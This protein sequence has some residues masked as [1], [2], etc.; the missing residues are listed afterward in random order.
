[1]AKKKSK[2]AQIGGIGVIYARFS[3]HN[4]RDVSIE[5]QVEA[6]TKKAAE[7]GINIL[8]VY[9]DRA[10]SGKTDKRADFQKMMRDAE[11]GKFQFVVAWK[12]NR[13]GRNMLEAMMNEAKLQA[14]GVRVIYV[15]ENFDDTAA[16]RFAARSMMNVNQFYSESMA[17]DIKRGMVD[18]AKK[19]M[20]NGRPNYGLKKS[21]DGKLEID[22]PAANVLLEIAER[23]IAQEPFVDIYNDLNARG[24]KSPSGGKWNRSSFQNLLTNER[25]RG[26]YIWGDIRIEGGLP[27]LM[28]DEMYYKLQEVLKTKKN[29]RGR[30]RVY[31]DYLLTGKLFCGHCNAPMTGYSGTSKSGALHH[32]YVCQKRRTEHTCKKENV[33]RDD[34]ELAVAQAIRD[35]ALQPDV[36]EW[37]ADSTVAYAKKQ[38]EGSHIAVLEDRLN[39]TNKSI[40]N[41]MNA[42]EQGIFTDTTRERLL[43]LEEEKSNLTIKIKLEKDNIIKVS[44]EDIITGLSMFR[45]GDLNDKNYIAKL[46]DTFLVAVYL[47]DNDMKIVFSFTGKNNTVNLPFDISKLEKAENNTAERCSYKLSSGRPN[48]AQTNTPTIFM[49]D[50]VFVLLCP[51]CKSQ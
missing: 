31:G 3:S 30:H 24:I 48:I 4:Q 22:V 23:V 33:R 41:I 19:C 44:K 29:A 10:V 20:I 11:K 40:N 13:I 32:Y 26:V 46:F 49:V 47:Y 12:S 17:E 2:K 51:F 16:G 15:E 6:A 25:N 35:Y 45:D 42:I 14:W 18:N 27:R 1:M 39:D 50:S 38:E 28:S 21:Q 5:Q 7:Y 9:S 36:I 43:Q 37:I 8:N 34:I